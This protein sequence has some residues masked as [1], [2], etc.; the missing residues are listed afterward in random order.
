MEEGSLRADANVSIRPV[1][2]KEF[3][4]RAEIKNVNSFRSLE[5]A[6][7]VEVKRQKALLL[8]GEVVLETRNYD[9]ATQTTTSLRGKE[10]AHDY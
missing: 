2:Q 6:I 9:E 7:N 4:T 1:G 8:A 3:G 5:R 10:E